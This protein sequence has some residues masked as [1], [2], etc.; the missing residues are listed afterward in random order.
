MCGVAGYVGLGHLAVDIRYDLVEALGAGIDKRG[1]HASGAVVIPD[2]DVGKP[3]LMRR[4]GKWDQARGRFIRATGSGHSAM[5]HARYATHGAASDVENAHPFAIK[6]EV[7]GKERT[8]LYGCHN[9]MLSGTDDTAKFFSRKHT[10]DS[11]E[12]FEL[13]ADGRHDLI[14][15]LEGYGVVT[16]IR[17]GDRK[18]R[19]LRL[20]SSSDFHLVRLKGGGI[21]WGSTESI[22]KAALEYCGL[23]VDKELTVGEIG[24]VY[25]L[26]GKEAT[27]SKLSGLEVQSFW[28][29]STANPYN[30]WYKDDTGN[31]RERKD[32]SYTTSAGFVG[33]RNVNRTYIRPGAF[34]SYAECEDGSYRMAD[35]EGVLLLGE[36]P[37]YVPAGEGRF[38]RIDSYHELIKT[39]FKLSSS[40]QS[41]AKPRTFAAQS[42]L[43][44][45]ANAKVEA[46]ATPP[47]EPVIEVA[48]VKALTMQELA[49]AMG[50]SL[51]D[52]PEEDQL[53]FLDF[54][55]ENPEMISCMVEH[56]DTEA[57]STPPS[58][59][60][61]SADDSFNLGSSVG[62]LCFPDSFYAQFLEAESAEKDGK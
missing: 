22:V 42:Y 25:V 37:I 23:E 1:G 29:K 51:P 48:E 61:A 12:F 55:Q 43:E 2:I 36:Y 62:E 24:R 32:S 13:L 4:L 45:Y 60:P 30:N 10:V 28:G 40:V 46:D 16:Y 33:S 56:E 59:A 58:S 11:K 9:G 47:T 20:S 38:K 31:W 7:D 54:F 53:A 18:V 3:R 21:V 52:M 19:V 14:R 34:W 50:V 57:V 26:S 44:R 39:E 17:P 35:K 15:N 27:E 6:R 49:E 8:V 5:M 41:K